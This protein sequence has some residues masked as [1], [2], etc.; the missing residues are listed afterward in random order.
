MNEEVEP[1]VNNVPWFQ[2][3]VSELL[4]SLRMAATPLQVLIRE[5]EMH[6]D[7]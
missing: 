7:M 5:S 6:K 1:S 3:K 4:L 2:I